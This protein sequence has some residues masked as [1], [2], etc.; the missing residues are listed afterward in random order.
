MEAPPSCWTIICAP[1]ESEAKV[2]MAIDQ[3]INELDSFQHKPKVIL[4]FILFFILCFNFTFQYLS[5]FFT[6]KK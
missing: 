2:L 3:N 1:E 6:A 4:F 5:N